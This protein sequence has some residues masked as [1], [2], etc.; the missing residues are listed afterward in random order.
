MSGGSYN[1]LF[2]RLDE[3]VPDL[4]R[5]IKRLRQLGF[6]AAAEELEEY[7]PP[8]PFE[9]LHELVRCVEWLDSADYELDQVTEA[10]RAYLAAKIGRE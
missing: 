2:A 9:P 4:D 10:N 5:M 1:Y 6:H 3:E 7:L 8:K